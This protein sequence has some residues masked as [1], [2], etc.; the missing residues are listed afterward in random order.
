MRS[1]LDRALALRDHALRIVSAL[2]Q[3]MTIG[4]KRHAVLDAAPWRIAF[5]SPFGASPS[6]LDP[7]T[8]LG[9]YQGAMQQQRGGRTN[10]DYSLS[11]WRGPK[12]LFVEWDA[13]TPKELDVANFKQSDWET[14]FLTWTI[15]P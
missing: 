8:G 4:D 5:S 10:L 2:G 11:I 1:R 9:P 6:R 14:D 3:V 15:T 7:A 13:A 12:V